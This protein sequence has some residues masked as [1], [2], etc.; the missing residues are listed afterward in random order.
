MKRLLTQTILGLGVAVAALA[1][2]PTLAQRSTSTFVDG[3]PDMTTY[4]GQARLIYLPNSVTRIAIGDEMIAD[5]KLISARQL[6][7]IGKSVGETNLILWHQDGSM[8]VIDAQV[9]IDLMPVRR[10]LAQALPNETQI[11]LSAAG[12]S[13]VLGGTVSNALTAEA[14]VS[15]VD[16]YVANLSRNYHPPHA[17]LRLLTGHDVTVSGKYLLHLP[18]LCPSIISFVKQNGGFI[19]ANPLTRPSRKTA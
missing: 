16:A 11:D 6:Y 3:G 1:P 2:A 7:L 13:I 17:A 14:V 8:S 4:L 15:M 12:A 5:V 18:S 10:M 9:T 19:P